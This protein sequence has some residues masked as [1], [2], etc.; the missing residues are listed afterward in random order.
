MIN[1]LWNLHFI[2]NANNRHIL[3]HPGEEAV[4]CDQLV[5]LCVCPAV[6]E[7]CSQ[8]DTH[9]DRQ[10][11]RNKLVCLFL[12]VCLSASISL[13]PLNRSSRNVCA[14]P[15]WPRC[16]TLCTSGFMDDVTFG[17]SGRYGDACLPLAALRYSGGGSLMSMNALLD[18]DVVRYRLSWL[19]VRF[20]RTSNVCILHIK[21]YT[22]KTLMLA[23][24]LFREFRQPNRT[25]KLK[26]AN[27][28][29]R[30]K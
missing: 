14:D 29:C 24:P 26:G 5:C 4:Y 8:T 22:V 6:S 10:A 11:N 17:R 9:T 13:E 12:C 1:R 18:F 28:N 20:E 3:L 2:F 27:I 16:N 30:P 19:L 15:L 21:S 23:C 7:I 25:A